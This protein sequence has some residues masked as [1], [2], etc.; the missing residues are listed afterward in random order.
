MITLAIYLALYEGSQQDE[1]RDAG[2]HDE[3][4][5][6]PEGQ[7]AHLPQSHLLHLQAQPIPL[8]PQ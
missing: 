5:E 3:V 8:V 4:D 1:N 7:T 6:V 2:S